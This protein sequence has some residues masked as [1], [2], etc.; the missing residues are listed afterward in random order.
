MNSVKVRTGTRTG[1]IRFTMIQAL[2][3]QAGAQGIICCTASAQSQVFTPAPNQVTTI[4]VD[5]KAVN[6][7]EVIDGEPVE[8]VDY[9]GISLLNSTSAIAFGGSQSLSSY[10]TPAFEPGATRLPGT[11]P[12]SVAPMIQAE[13]TPCASASKADASVSAGCGP[14]GFSVARRVVLSKQGSRARLNLQ[15]PGRGIV[16]IRGIGRGARL[17]SATRKKFNRSGRASVFV[18]LN[19]RGRRALNRGGRIVVPLAV[20][21][22]PKSGK[23][24]TKRLKVRFARR[25]S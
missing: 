2:R 20:S 7:V 17:V 9:L 24:K 19:T 25:G 10:F 22:R 13:L 3:S 23:T 8:V 12:Y 14:A 21:F 4:R 16:S 1:P 18:L 15:L 11:L 6:T 5:M